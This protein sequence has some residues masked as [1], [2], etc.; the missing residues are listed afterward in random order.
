MQDIYLF[1]LDCLTSYDSIG[2]P[3]GPKSKMP[4]TDFSALFHK[5]FPHIADNVLYGE[6]VKLHKNYLINLED[7]RFE[8]NVP[9]VDGAIIEMT[10]RGFDH[11]FNRTFKLD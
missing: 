2:R 5:K 9:L 11:F 4:Y 6:A 10:K 8:E 1:I 3:L 7:V